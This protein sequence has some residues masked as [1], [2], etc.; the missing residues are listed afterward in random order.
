MRK[1]AILSTDNLEDFFVYDRMLIEPL[2]K[3]G[4]EAEEVSWHKENHNWGQYDAVVVRSTWDYQAH[5][6]AFLTRLREIDASNAQLLNPLKLIE[7]NVSKRYLKELEESGVPIVPTLWVDGEVELGHFHAAFSQFDTEELV[8]KPF[9]SANA[10]FTYRVDKANLPKLFEQIEADFKNR[11]AMIQPFIKSI[12]EEG[13]YSLFYFD[14]HY[15]H[16]IC[17]QPAKGDFRVQEE[18]G[19]ELSAIKPS[20][21]ML[22]LA[23]QTIAA[24]PTKALYAR[25]D[26][27][28][29]NHSLVI[30][31]VELIEPSLYFNMDDKSAERFAD[32]FVT[33][34]N[35]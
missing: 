17:K 13:E 21:A 22:D 28:N 12:I 14:G 24:L 35:A 4:W 10:D 15:S 3:R 27:V 26:M 8:I 1:L 20:S 32:I 5:C 6:D 34:F 16:T 23:Q 31:E 11:S 7:W 29:C 19:G 2:A 33:S 9:I 30:I 18:H 25:V